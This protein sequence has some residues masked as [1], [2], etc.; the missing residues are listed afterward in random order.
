MSLLDQHFEEAL[1]ELPQKRLSWTA[2]RRIQKMLSRRTRE[3][4]RLPDGQERGMSWWG[5]FQRLVAVPVAMVLILVATGGYGFTSSTVVKGDFLYT[6]KSQLEPYLY[7]S[8][9]SSE[10]RIAFHLWLSDR[11][12]AE[13]SEILNRL[14]KP[15]LVFLPSVYAQEGD[16][17][18]TENPLDQLLFETLQSAVKQVDYALLITDEIRDVKR[19]ASI[20]SEIR[21]SLEKQ[22]MFVEEAAPV[23]HKVRLKQKRFSRQQTVRNIIA[24]ES[25]ALTKIAPSLEPQ[26]TSS[27]ELPAIAG[28][29]EN[30]SPVPLAFDS[31][32]DEPLELT[33]VAELIE[34][35]LAFQE[36]LLV[37]VE[38]SVA[39]ADFERKTEVILPVTEEL[40]LITP[41]PDDKTSKKAL[42]VHYEETKKVLTKEIAMA[43]GVVDIPI[44][45]SVSEKEPASLEGVSEVSVEVPVLESPAETASDLVTEAEEVELGM[46][47]VESE[48]SEK[49]L[50]KE[51]ESVP[52]GIVSESAV[53][54]VDTA[55]RMVDEIMKEKMEKEKGCEK[56]ASELCDRDRL[57][58]CFKKAV[59]DCLEKKDDDKGINDELN[60]KKKRLLEVDQKLREIKKE[61]TLRVFP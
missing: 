1:R 55:V 30:S 37:K 59:Q 43:E 48:V 28:D 45:A 52:E 3:L 25:A 8:N 50:S 2:N 12:Y 16:V 46:V 42:T 7:P 58:E 35:Q 56:K 10:E 21:I 9:G 53:T 29:S 15:S 61:E 22:K 11:R 27:A 32:V 4:A 60:D 38:N 39:K 20:K 23:L 31:V 36:Y 17:E 14:G 5:I 41:T 6:V 19:V 57:E 49:P 47:P 40:A 33:T 44:E 51:P 54:E 18:N 24:S 34:D 13:V 26:N